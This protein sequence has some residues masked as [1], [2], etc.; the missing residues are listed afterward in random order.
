MKPGDRVKFV[1]PS[2]TGFCGTDVPGKTVAIDHNDAGTALDESSPGIWHVVFD[3]IPGVRVVLHG[4]FLV[5]IPAAQAA[6]TQKTNGVCICSTNQL[7][8]AGCICGAIQLERKK[9]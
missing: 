8:F 7:V 4:G 5:E 1:W 2:G 9:K 3:K 6:T